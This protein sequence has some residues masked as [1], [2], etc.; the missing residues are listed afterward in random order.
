MK[1]NLRYENHTGIND[2][3]FD[4]LK[5]AIDS[6]QCID[7]EIADTSKSM[8]PLLVAG[9][10]VTI[11]RLEIGRIA[12]GDMVVFKADNGLCVH[13]YIRKISKHND[14]TEFLMKGDNMLK[15][16]VPAVLA[17]DILGKVA[18]IKK[19]NSKINVKNYCWKINNYILAIISIVQLTMIIMGNSIKPMRRLRLKTPAPFRMRN[20]LLFPLHF[21]LRLMVFAYR[22]FSLG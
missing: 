16:D 6:G 17:D 8:Y 19:S 10:I 3:A 18:T 22:V 20:F 2:V 15:V 14:A 21:S 5:Q 13:R 1:E 12:R 9:D 11:T 7:F 4:L